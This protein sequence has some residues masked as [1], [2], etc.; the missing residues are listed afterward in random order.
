M[1]IAPMVNKDCYYLPCK[2]NVLCSISQKFLSLISV[3]SVEITL[4][5]TLTINLRL[6]TFCEIDP[7]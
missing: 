3:V 1:L 4:T 7:K 5:I 6:T 2:D